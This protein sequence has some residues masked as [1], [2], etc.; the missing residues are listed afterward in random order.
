MK[1]LHISRFDRGGANA[2]R[3]LHYGLLDRGYESDLLTL[4]N[5]NNT[6]RRKYIFQPSL[7]QKF[8]L[9]DRLRIKLKLQSPHSF[10]DQQGLQ[11]KGYSLGYGFTFP[12]T[13]HDITSH[14]LYQQADILHLHWVNDFL[15]YPSFFSKNQKPILWT[16][17]DMHPFTGGFFYSIGTDYQAKQLTNFIHP[18]KTNLDILLNKNTKTKIQNIENQYIEVLATT[19]TMKKLSEQ[20]QILK[21]FKHH[22]IPL[23]LD[24]KVFKPYDKF[25][26]RTL[27][28]LPSD[29]PVLVFVSASLDNQFKGLQLLIEAV[30]GLENPPYLLAIG[31]KNKAFQHIPYIRF[32]DYI[33]DEKLMALAYSAGD[34]FVTPSLQEAFGQTTI[35]ALCCGLPVISFETWGGLDLV[36]SENGIRVKKMNIK[37]LR[38]AIQQ[39]LSDK[40]QFNPQKIREDAIQ[41]YNLDHFINQHIQLYQSL[42]QS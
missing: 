9:Q 12:E 24:T 27:F 18:E 5:F 29:I 42:L 32:T 11:L 23:G 3:R 21:S 31:Q 34:F 36:N 17:H 1:I 22:L 39:I 8:T 38:R 19:Q 41:K 15:D 28:D 33:S 16:L 6:K 26:C 35:E 37:Y 7:P 13:L 30:S 40:I 4:D 2:V 20:S 10:H 14:P 25:F